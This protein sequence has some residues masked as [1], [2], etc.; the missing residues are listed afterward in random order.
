MSTVQAPAPKRANRLKATKRNNEMVTAY[1]ESL[2]RAPEEGKLVCWYEGIQL[3]P[4]LQAADIAWCHGEAMSAL[5]A[6]RNEEGP[7]QDAAEAAGYDRELCSY[8]RTHI[9]CGIL[10]QRDQGPDDVM[11]TDLGHRVPAP[12]M[13]IS[14]YPF[15]STGQQWDDMIY[16]TFGKH[17]PI[18]NISMPWVWGNKKSAR[19]MRGPEFR[20]S[21]DFMVAQLRECITFIEERT[22][23]AYDYDRLREVMRYTRTAAELRLQAMDLCRTTPS[24]ASFFEWT[25]SIAPVNFLPGDQDIVDYFADKKAEIAERVQN[26]I[27]AVPEERYRLYWDGIMNW[28]KIGW[29]ADKFAGYDA[30]VVSGRYTHLGFWQH[31][32]VIDVDGDPL[33]GMAQNYLSCPISISAPQVIELTLQH[34]RDYRID[35]MILH[36]AHTCRAFSYPQFLIGEA[37]SSNLKMPTAMFEGDMVDESFYQDELVNSRVEAM[38]EQIDA[39]RARA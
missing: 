39:R 35:G 34:C 23:H 30:C 27:G 4:I 22:G 38:L 32:D 14:A 19:Y 18:F 12:D 1:W 26:G 6:A 5:L 33:D 2:F 29:L 24:P 13:I 37:V 21:V 3:N 11:P 8:A 20:E 28:N 15:C 25:N 16:R 31:P 10:T 17:V 9:G 7:A 36:G